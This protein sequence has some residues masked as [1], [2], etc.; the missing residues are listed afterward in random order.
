LVAAAGFDAMKKGAERLAP[1]TN[2]RMW[3]DNSR[4][5]NKGGSGQ[6]RGVLSAES[7]ALMDQ[8]KA[9]YPSDFI[10]WLFG[11]PYRPLQPSG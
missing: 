10:D 9:R 7:L 1:D 5:F 6:W 3:K 11:G 4:F 8:V 2:F